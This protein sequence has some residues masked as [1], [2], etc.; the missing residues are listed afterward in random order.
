MLNIQ[1]RLLVRQL[2]NKGSVFSSDDSDSESDSGH[3]DGDYV[4]D[5]KFEDEFGNLDDEDG[6]KHNCD[7]SDQSGDTL[8]APLH[9]VAFLLVQALTEFS[10]RDE[11]S[12]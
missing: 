12:K 1:T 11:L 4:I 9:S 5:K 3:D 6:W 8:N 7:I 10:T 2:D